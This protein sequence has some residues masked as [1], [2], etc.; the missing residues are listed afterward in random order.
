MPTRSEQLDSMSDSDKERAILQGLREHGYVR[1]TSRLALAF[2]GA[3]IDRLREAGEIETEMVENH[4]QQHS[5][6][7]VTPAR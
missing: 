6:L 1:I 5:Y 7:R 2:W 4:E 3:A